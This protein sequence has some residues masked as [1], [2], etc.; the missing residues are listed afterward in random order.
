MSGP[1]QSYNNVDLDRRRAALMSAIAATLRRGRAEL[2][3]SQREFAQ[4]VGF[5]QSVVARLEAER[6][7]PPMSTALAVL[8]GVGARLVVPDAPEPTRMTGEYA[9][10]EAGRRLPAHLEPYRLAEPHNWWPG[11]TQILMWRNQPRWSY[12]RI[13]SGPPPG[14]P[15]WAIEPTVATQRA[16]EPTAPPRQARR[17]EP[18]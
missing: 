6:V 4:R 13:L 5:S 2:G 1:A 15:P 7:D 11:Q 18:C 12:R 10:D 17:S 3:W 16:I 9:R 14:P 8:D